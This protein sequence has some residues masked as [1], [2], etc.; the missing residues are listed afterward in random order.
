ME[1]KVDEQIIKMAIKCI[2]KAIEMG[3]Y[4]N[5]IAPSYPQIIINRLLESLGE[6]TK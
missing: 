3:A 5:M 2:A 1:I 6:V 4:K